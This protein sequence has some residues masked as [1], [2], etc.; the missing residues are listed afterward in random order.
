MLFASSQKK[1]IAPP[2]KRWMIFVALVSGLWLYS[3]SQAEARRAMIGFSGGGGFAAGVSLLGTSDVLFPQVVFPA[4]EIRLFRHGRQ[5]TDIQILLLNTIF[6]VIG[7]AIR[8]GLW[9]PLQAGFYHTFRVGGPFARFIVA[10]GAQIDLFFSTA[11]SSGLGFA[12]SV[13]PGVR[14]GIEMKFS[15]GFALEIR[16]RPFAFLGFAIVGGG[17]LPA[18]GGGLLG[19]VAFYF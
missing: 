2:F 3:Q 12:M 6:G 15:P 5:S 16:A 13:N 14:L 11:G 19:E 9:L 10:P 8:G 17:I 18:F 1:H 7:G 4:L